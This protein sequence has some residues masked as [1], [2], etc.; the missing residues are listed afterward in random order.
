VAPRVICQYGASSDVERC[1][2]CIGEVSKIN[3]S[4]PQICEALRLEAI[5]FLG[6]SFKAGSSLRSS[7]IASR[8]GGNI[9]NAVS[10]KLARVEVYIDRAL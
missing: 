8:A 3:A 5:L 10:G 6:C 9:C 7:V 4:I 1:A 2:F